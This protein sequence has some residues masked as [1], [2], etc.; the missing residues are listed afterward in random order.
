MSAQHLHV[1]QSYFQVVI[2]HSTR[3]VARQTVIGA[4]LDDFHAA[5]AL[6]GDMPGQCQGQP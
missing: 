2:Q 6:R 5:I 4:E 3:R 1:I